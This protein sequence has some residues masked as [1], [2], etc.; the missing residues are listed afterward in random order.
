MGT[1]SSVDRLNFGECNFEASEEV[2][3]INTEANFGGKM[4]V[5]M[6]R[7]IQEDKAFVKLGKHEH[8]EEVD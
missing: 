7:D 6:Y 1:Q 5:V 3:L 4:R 2:R 8:S